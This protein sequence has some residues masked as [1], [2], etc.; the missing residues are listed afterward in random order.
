MLKQ[1][2]PT[3]IQYHTGLSKNIIKGAEYVVLP[4]DPHRCESIAKAFDP[5]AIFLADSREHKSY[6]A[7]FHGKNILVCSSGL[8]APNMG[9]TLEEL[10]VIGLKYFLRIG[11]CGAIQPFIDLGDIV[12][13]TASVRLDG[14]SKDYAPVEYP[15]VAS[16]DFTLDMIEGAKKAKAPFHTGITASTDTFW[17]AQ[18]RYD[19]YTGHILRS[20]RGSTDEWRTLNV[21]NYEMESSAL[22]VMASVMG[23]HA[24]C[25]CGV[26]AKRVESEKISLDT[27]KGAAKSN[28]EKVAVEGIY[29]SMKR[30]GMVK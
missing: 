29:Q 16:F 15:A 27:K 4:G 8:G 11:T 28:W 24:A 20:K 25:I 3:E 12:I 7:H 26:V 13:S 23:L 17:Q 2:K 21:L 18:E 5:N 30:R 14:A 22:F 19:S 9:I 1:A 10:A 6:L